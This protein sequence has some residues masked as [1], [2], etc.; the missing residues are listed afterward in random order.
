VLST[1]MKSMRWSTAASSSMRIRKSPSPEA[2]SSSFMWRRWARAEIR[3]SRAISRIGGAQILRE[4]HQE[5]APVEGKVKGDLQ[6]RL[7]YRHVQRRAFCPIS[8]IEH[9]SGAQTP[10]CTWG[11]LPVPDTRFETRASNIV[12][13]R[14]AFFNR[15]LE[16]RSKT[17]P[18]KP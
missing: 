17:V 8:Q 4:A 13:S 14:R 1:R 6:G 11:H 12:V 9:F 16:G 5:S 3:L 10:P 18:W 2:M 7:P 15:E